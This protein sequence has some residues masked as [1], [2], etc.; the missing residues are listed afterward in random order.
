MFPGLE[1]QEKVNKMRRQIYEIIIEVDKII[2][3]NPFGVNQHEVAIKAGISQHN[4]KTILSAI[5]ESG[6][7]EKKKNLYFKKE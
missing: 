4:A 6:R 5:A 1:R 2:S 7:I 3:T